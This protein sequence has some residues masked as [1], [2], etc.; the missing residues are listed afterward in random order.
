MQAAVFL[1]RDG[2]LIEDVDLLTKTEQFRILPNVAEA[3]TRLKRAR[4][5]LIVVSNQSVVARGLASEQQVQA[6]NGHLAQ[7]LAEAGGPALDGWYFCP[8]H[9]KAT[10]ASYRM[11]CDCR[12]P[13]IGLMLSASREHGVDLSRSFMVGDRPSDVVAG[14]NAG[15]RTILVQ[16]GRHLEGPIEMTQPMDPNVVSDHSCADLAAAATWILK[17]L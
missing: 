10:Q 8:H 13:G 3:L 5:R 16:T 4:F 7:L 6:L 9:P 1:D 14:R 17:M 11:D 12:K 2:V 15:C